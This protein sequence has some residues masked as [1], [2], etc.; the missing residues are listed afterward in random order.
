M[1]TQ[2]SPSFKPT[3]ALVQARHLTVKLSALAL[4]ALAALPAAQAGCV[5]ERTGEAEMTLKAG[6]GCFA[7]D[8][9]E[10]RR[11]AL[12]IQHAA[13]ATGRG[14]SRPSASQRAAQRLA[15][16]RAQRAQLASTQTGGTASSA[17][18]VKLQVAM[19]NA[20]T[21]Q[22]A[23]RTAQADPDGL[24]RAMIRLAQLRESEQAM[25]AASGLTGGP[26]YYGQGAAQA[27]STTRP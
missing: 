7:S 27:P 23:L 1:P 16:V 11:L 2:R 15:Q 24:R 8:N 26:T 17:A 9:E 13:D 14:G 5:L 22:H 4:L 21:A 25:N 20:P 18:A 3:A 10:T 12:D 19:A 6:P